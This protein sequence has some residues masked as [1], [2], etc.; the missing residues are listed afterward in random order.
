MTQNPQDPQRPLVLGDARNAQ[1]VSLEERQRH[2]QALRQWQDHQAKGLK[3]SAGKARAKS[4]AVTTVGSLLLLGFL[5]V[6]GEAGRVDPALILIPT[7]LAVVLV[8]LAAVLSPWPDVAKALRQHKK[9]R[10][11]ERRRKG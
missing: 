11:A 3:R 2:Q 9:N 4:V 7:A 8:A 6:Q 1:H 10:R 5:W